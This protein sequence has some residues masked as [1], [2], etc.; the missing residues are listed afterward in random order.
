M[1]AAATT[2]ASSSAPPAVPATHGVRRAPRVGQQY[3][4]AREPWEHGR[5]LATQL[6]FACTMVSM[7]GSPRRTAT[8]RRKRAAIAHELLN[9][10]PSV[11]TPALFAVLCNPDH[12]TL[13]HWA[14]LMLNEHGCDTCKA[15]NFGGGVARGLDDT[16]REF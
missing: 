16:A 2:S 3:H 7:D 1:C 11:R 14:M 9:A 10:A 8:W 15:P 12:L 5:L 13:R 4:E 6:A